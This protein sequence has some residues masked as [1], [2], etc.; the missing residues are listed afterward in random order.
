MQIFLIILFFF[1]WVSTHLNYSMAK[2]APN[3]AELYACRQLEL[4]IYTEC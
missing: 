3:N 2:L 1:A 4:A